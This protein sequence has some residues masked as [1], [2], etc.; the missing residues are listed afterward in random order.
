MQRL[1]PHVFASL[2]LGSLAPLAAQDGGD[3]ASVRW[4][5]T[6][7]LL[8][9]ELAGPPFVDLRPHLSAALLYAL[10]PDGFDVP[11]EDPT[12][13]AELGVGDL[14]ATLLGELPEPLDFDLDSREGVVRVEG[15]AAVHA[16]VARRLA[17]LT[18]LA[19][20]HVD[21]EVWRVPAVA[22][23][24]SARALLPRDSA[25]VVPAMQG[26]VL[27]ARRPVPL[28]RAAS[29]ATPASE[30][31]LYDYDVEVAQA[32][33]AVDPQ[34]TIV[35]TGLELGA[36][37]RLAADGRLLVRAWG[38][39]GRLDRPIREVDVAGFDGATLEL[40]RMAVTVMAGSACLEA[41]E[42]LVLGAG[43]DAYV[44]RFQKGD[45]T[46]AIGA[47]ASPFVP[48]GTLT[49]TA[50]RSPRLEV[51][52]ATPSGGIEPLDRDRPS[53]LGELG[54]VLEP[55]EL[56]DALRDLRDAR[57]LP[58]R[59]ALLGDL[60]YVPD[61]GPLR[62]AI[63]DELAALAVNL[64]S[65]TFDIELRYGTLRPE[66]VASL[67]S[68]DTAALAAQLPARLLGAAR[69]GESLILVQGREAFEL[70]DFDVEIAQA[71][72]V[73]DPVVAPIFHGVTVSCIPLRA[74]DGRVAAALE[75]VHQ[76]HR[77]P[78]RRT[79]T[80]D[81][82]PEPTT[83]LDENPQPIGRLVR[84][85]AIELPAT[86]RVEVRATAYAADG[87]WC[88]VQLAPVG[89]GSDDVLAVVA[90]INGRR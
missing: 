3:E 32:A 78:S 62:A 81:W 68:A 63:R 75:L 6:R 17:E 45:G 30:S 76:V 79:L 24:A 61:D 31:I 48:T 60:V 74:P 33:L 15:S 86:T 73:P 29:L 19:T 22:L 12:R 50:A 52:Q 40:P 10:Q 38:R 56:F 1:A 82:D 59:M 64:A 25:E 49:A 9:P 65:E 35:R 55:D 16:E 28:G 41:G 8:L 85:N 71:S 7:A 2:A 4:Y 54:A 80:A 26:A 83:T 88:L 77:D 36:Q 21:V 90:R 58:G 72:A 27:V 57:G 67:D 70:V 84:R 42:A 13:F 66:Q 20:A 18:A 43:A 69:A 11:L 39:D 37:V 5:D 87:A 46:A 23:P 51:R 34:V 89:G 53:W 14:L 47:A 44:L